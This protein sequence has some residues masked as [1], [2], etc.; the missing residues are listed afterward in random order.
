MGIFRPMTRR[1]KSRRPKSIRPISHSKKLDKNSKPFPYSQYYSNS[2]KQH[3]HSFEW[4]L[5][6]SLNLKPSRITVLKSQFHIKSNIQHLYIKIINYSIIK[7]VATNE[8]MNINRVKWC[9]QL[10][11]QNSIKPQHKN[12]IGEWKCP[13]KTVKTDV[14]CPK[15][16]T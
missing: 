15:Y 10:Q 16:P 14:Q 11:F 3:A 9:T 4:S 7:Y 5:C 2:Q 1:P 12:I 13:N 8:T 6:L